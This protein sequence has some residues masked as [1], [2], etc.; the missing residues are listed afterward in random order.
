MRN[1]M[2]GNDTSKFRGGYAKLYD[3]IRYNF[4]QFNFP[5]YKYAKNVSYVN[6]HVSIVGDKYRYHFCVPIIQNSELIEIIFVSI[7]SVKCAAQV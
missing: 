7:F 1:S 2:F 5:H 4:D 6:R 3:W